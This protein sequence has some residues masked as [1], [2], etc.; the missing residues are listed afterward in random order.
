[1]NFSRKDFLRTSILTSAGLLP[2]L[3]ALDDNLFS[4]PQNRPHSHTQEDTGCSISIF[5]KHLQWLDYPEMAQV[6]A[7]L[8][9]DGVDLTVRPG[10]HV[11]PEHAERDLP[12]AVEAVREAGLEVHM[13]ST[14]IGDPDE[15]HTEAILKTASRLDI[16]HYRTDWFPYDETKNVTQNLEAFRSK[17]Q[18]LAEINSIYG[19][20]GDY[21]NHAGT[22][23]GAS[24][25]DLWL[26]LKEMDTGWIGSQYD[27]R[28]ATVEGARSWQNG[29]AAIHPYIGTLDIKDFHW[30]KSEGRWQEQNVPLGEGMVDF[31]TYFELLKE[32]NV[33][34]PIS[35]HYEYD[36]GG[37][38]HGATTLTT[39]RGEVL[40]A[41]RRDLGILDRWL[42]DAGLERG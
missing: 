36:L 15:E 8:G 13:I 32:H 40:A 27:I 20:Q 31:Q 25:W 37:A 7:D 14:A 17:L 2:G 21:Q 16:G 42:G 5:S 26:V 33:Q 24:I 38:N 41:F 30:V 28:H 34:V 18:R 3:N 9:F 35:L 39:G 1:M 10:G 29:F 12:R 19:I 22:S 11:L 23:F 6:A 4:S